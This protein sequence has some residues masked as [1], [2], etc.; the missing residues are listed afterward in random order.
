[1]WV[2]ERLSEEGTGKGRLNARG[3]I[4]GKKKNSGQRYLAQKVPY[5]HPGYD[6][7]YSTSA[8][9]AWRVCLQPLQQLQPPLLRVA[10]VNVTY[11]AGV[12][13]LRRERH[14]QRP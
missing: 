5:L 13:L 11:L 10:T 8:H 14:A 12:R 7:A 1:V 6:T 4:S 3:E 2:R 9:V